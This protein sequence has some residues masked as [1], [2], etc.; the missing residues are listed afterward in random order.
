MKNTEKVMKAPYWLQ[1]KGVSSKKSTDKAFKLDWAKAEYVPTPPKQKRKISVPSTK[2]INKNVAEPF[3]KPLAKKRPETPKKV[4]SQ[5]VTLREKDLVVPAF[6]F[7]QCQVNNSPTVH[8]VDTYSDETF[9]VEKMRTVK[10]KEIKQLPVL[11]ADEINLLQTEKAS[12]VE[13]LNVVQQNI[14]EKAS[15]ASLFDKFIVK[16]VWKCEVCLANRNPLSVDKCQACETPRPHTNANSATSLPETEANNN[17]TDSTSIFGKPA[18]KSAVVEDV[19]KPQEQTKNIFATSKSANE[20]KKETTKSLFQFGNASTDKPMESALFG[21]PKATAPEATCPVVEEKETGFNL[22]GSSSTKPITNPFAT[23]KE[24]SGDSVPTKPSTSI[25]GATDVSASSTSKPLFSST[26]EIGEKGS[27]S[28]FGSGLNTKEVKNPFLNTSSDAPEQPSLFG[29][30]TSQIIQN[31]FLTST[32]KPVEQPSKSLF[33]VTSSTQET[34]SASLFGAATSSQDTGN[35]ANSLFGAKPSSNTG[36][37][38]FGAKPS[39]TFGE[40]KPSNPFGGSDFGGAK[41]SSSASG[42]GLFGS[43]QSQSNSVFSAQPT[44]FGFNGAAEVSNP[45]QSAAAQTSS[46]NFSIG[47]SNVRKKGKKI[48]K[49]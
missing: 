31:P 40:T 21:A 41:D 18:E 44:T 19:F 27:T 34:N 48:R 20:E 14:E 3:I 25:F 26:T 12:S 1:D 16:D 30:G 42:I 38:M 22:F 13:P 35:S 37:S 9:K 28:L 47:A 7:V 33:G 36:N 4:E 23:T 10:K 39:N 49:R 11:E 29:S 32:E 5:R 15:S 45:F 46:N 6:K 24:V 8:P 43:T 2:T 17:I